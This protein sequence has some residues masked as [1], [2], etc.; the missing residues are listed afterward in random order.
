MRGTKPLVLVD[1]IEREWNKLNMQDIESVTVLK[2]ATAVAPYGLKGANGV[3]LVTTKRGNTGKVTLTYNGE[4]GWQKPT[5][6]PEFMS[7]C[8]RIK[9]T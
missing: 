8:G 3:I 7:A 2:D 5:N 9:A 4:Y 1:G 6:T